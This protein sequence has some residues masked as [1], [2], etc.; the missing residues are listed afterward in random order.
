MNLTTIFL[1]GLGTIAIW[2][3]KGQP[4]G[5]TKKNYRRVGN[6]MILMGAVA[7]LLDTLFRALILYW[8]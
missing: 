8:G 1:V 3:A 6:A 5:R 4:E 7:L 2:Q